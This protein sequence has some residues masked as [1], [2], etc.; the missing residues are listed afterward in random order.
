MLTAGPARK[1]I[2]TV[3]EADRWHGRSVHNAL[4][5]VLP[6]RAGRRHRLPRDRRLHGPRVDPDD[7]PDGRGDAPAREDRGSRHRRGD[8]PRPARRLRHRRA[9]PRG[10]AGDA[11]REIRDGRGGGGAAAA[12]EGGPACNSSGRPGCSTST[13]ATD[14]WEG[15]PLHETIVKRARL[16][17]IAETPISTAASSATG[18]GGSTSTT[19]W[20]SR[21]TTR[22][23]SPSSTRRRRW[24]PRR[25]GRHRDG[26]M[27]H[28]DLRRHGGEV[29]TA[30]GGSRGAGLSERMTAAEAPTSGR[31]GWL[32]RSTVGVALADLSD[33]SHEL[34]TA[35]LPTVLLAARRGAGGARPH[36]GLAALSAHLAWD[37]GEERDALV[38]AAG[39]PGVPARSR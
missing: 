33:V 7:R 32:N 6:S 18:P 15:E 28:R 20:R 10:A 13:S 37:S 12:P 26:G 11:D 25:A 24:L 38:A 5:E 16:L 31:A 22:S 4:L 14:R 2:V 36:R 8:R 35:V 30:R 39:P 19:R 21:A 17:D 34:A 1:L 23:S 3:N 27:P 29:R 9:W